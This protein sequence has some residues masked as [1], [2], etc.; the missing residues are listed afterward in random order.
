[1]FSRNQSLPLVVGYVVSVYAGDLDDGKSTT[2]Y[3]Y[4]LAG[5][6]IC[7]KS[8]VQS[9]VAMSTTYADYLAVAEAT[10]E[11][12]WLTVSVWEMGV[13]QGEVKLHCD[14]QSEIYLENN[15]VYHAR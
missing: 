5:G 15:Q 12:S 14:N 6:P 8:S 7:W 4:R 2:S 13:E 1:M 9:I 3:V 11:A 10:K